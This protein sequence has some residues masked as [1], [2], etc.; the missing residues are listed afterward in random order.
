VVTKEQLLDS[1][2]PGLTVVEASL[3]TGISKL[4]KALGD[5]D[6]TIVVTVQRVGYRLAAP[7]H[8][9]TITGSYSS[10]EPV[11]TS[12]DRVPRRQPWRLVRALAVPETRNVWLA[13][14][15]GTHERRVFKFAN[16]GARLKSLKREVTVARFLRQ[17]LGERR[18]LIRLLEWNFD[19]PPYSVESEYGGSNLVEW[20]EAQGGLHAVP[21]DDRLR[22]LADVARAVAAAHEAGVLHRDLKPANILIDSSAAPRQIR[23]VDFGSAALVEPERLQTL[24]ITNLGLTQTGAARDSSL[25]GSLMYLAPELFSGATP[26]ASADIYALGVMLYQLAVG[27]FHKPLSPGWEIDVQDPVLRQDIALA[28]SGDPSRRLDRAADVAN[29]IET[30]D[31]RREQHAHL[32]QTQ[33]HDAIA[34][35]KQ[36]EAR[37]RRPWMLVA[38][39]AS[40]VAAAV[41]FNVYSRPATSSPRSNA[42]AVLPFENASADA[43]LDFLRFALPD[44]IATTLS[45]MRPLAIRPSA[46]T[47]QYSAAPVDLQRVARELAANRIVTGRY[48]LVGEELQITVEATDTDSNHLVWRDTV[49][50]SAKNLLGL[51]AQISAMSKSKLAAALGASEFVRNTS[52][53]PKNE[54]AYDLYLRTV[55]M[56][57]D[58]EPN[59][60]AMA[61]LDRALELDSTYAPA[62][63]AL[64]NRAYEKSRFG[65]GGPA[66]LDRSDAAAER[67]LS[68]DPD[69]IDAAAE[70]TLH[71]VERGDLIGALKQ[72]SDMVRRRPDNAQGHHLLNYALRYAGFLEEAGKQC[73]TAELLDPVVTWG[74]CSSTFMELGRYA[75]AKDFIRK[76]LSSEWSKAHAVEILVREGK[77]KD[78]I[79]IGPPAIAHWESYKMLLAC[80]ARRPPS[81]IDALATR[82]EVS[83]D[84]EVN[85]FFAGHL[86]YCARAE[87]AVRFLELAVKGNHCSYPA[88]D[89]DPFFDPI[90]SSAGFKRARELAMACREKLATAAKSCCEN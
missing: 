73:D 57:H 86:A 43:S 49:N 58:P 29:R 62:W 38:A 37:V 88:I 67:A 68:L 17:S 1:V 44:E 77:L 47:S 16:A 72:A 39:V 48:L 76:D 80:A 66:M 21:V 89:Q 51:Q 84:P 46:A 59:V 53:P 69:Y 26:S 30:L 41:T 4:R 22:L 60:Q 78:A 23:V 14:H 36:A 45:R 34:Q 52:P 3:A 10:A 28:A 20:A 71:R 74:S 11:F 75:R 8:V 27:N 12:G 63:A 65:G 18:D 81:E 61:M 85:Y 83:D 55:A 5:R 33:A 6:A 32:E 19:A 56:S 9:S 42:V 40:A 31:R 7:V 25:A 90:R 35:R 70:L 79:Q 82:V 2:W 50:V 24:G 13:E 54:E 64:S 87:D 15:P